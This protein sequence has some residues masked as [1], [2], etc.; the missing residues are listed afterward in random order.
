MAGRFMGPKAKVAPELVG[1]WEMSPDNKFLPWKKTLTIEGNAAYT[2]VSQNDGSTT[3]GKIDVRGTR[4]AARDQSEPASGQMML[5]DDS[6]EVSTIWYEFVGKDTMRITDL[7]GT[8]YDAR[9]RQ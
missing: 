7:D 6:G 8:K 3:R 9:R 5:L 1:V 2:L 4:S